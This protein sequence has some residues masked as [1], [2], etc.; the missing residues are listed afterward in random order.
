V[1][2]DSAFAD[3]FTIAVAMG[4]LVSSSVRNWPL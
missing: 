3:D 4:I 2:A 1:V